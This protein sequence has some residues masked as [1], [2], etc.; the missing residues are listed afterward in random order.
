MFKFAGQARAALLGSLFAIIGFSYALATMDGANGRA[1][2]SRVGV[3]STFLHFTNPFVPSDTDR[4]L[5]D[6]VA[7]S[8]FL[9]IARAAGGVGPYRFAS[10]GTVNQLLFSEELENPVWDNT[11]GAYII[12]P[13]AAIAPDGNAGAER[14]QKGNDAATDLLQFVPNPNLRARTVTFSIFIRLNST[15]ALG[16]KI[17]ITIWD[18]VSG[19]RTR[20]VL[21]EVTTTGFTRVALT[22]VIHAD[23]TNAAVG[24]GLGMAPDRDFFAWGAQLEIGSEPTGYLKTTNVPSS[25]SPFGVIVPIADAIPSVDGKDGIQ[26]Q[27]SVGLNG[28]V[29][30][31]TTNAFNVS[32]VRFQIVVVDKATTFQ[33]GTNGIGNFRTEF[34]RLTLVHTDTF[35]F[36]IDGMP[37]AVQLQDYFMPL[38]VIN[39]ITLPL[40]FTA[41]NLKMNGVAI[42]SLEDIGLSLSVKDGVVFGKPLVAGTLTFT[43]K[44][45]NGTNVTA[46]SRDASKDDQDFTLIIDPNTIVTTTL[47]T[48][49]LTI[50][51]D[52]SKRVGTVHFTGYPH[53]NSTNFKIL[54]GQD[55][56]LRVGSYVA[57][58][59]NL[60]AQVLSGA[61]TSIK[62]T[63]TPIAKTKNNAI[64]KGKL[65]SKGLLT[66]SVTN[67]SFGD[68]FEPLTDGKDAT[69]AVYT[70]IGGVTSGSEMLRF[71]VKKRGTKFSLTY[72]S[73]TN[74]S[75]GGGF[76]LT[77]VRAK[78]LLGGSA[79][80]FKVGFVAFPP[81]TA[82]GAKGTYAG[83]N[84]G[85]VLIG[86]FYED[87]F[88]VTEKGGKVSF[89]GTPA[90]GK[91]AK[92]SMDPK[93]GKGSMQTGFLDANQ[94]GVPGASTVQ[95]GA[96]AN[97]T[98]HV[99]LSGSGPIFAGEGGIQIF[100]R[101]TDWAENPVRP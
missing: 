98:M 39:P 89:S 60:P 42:N 65:S 85:Q 15:P 84:K 17:P 67:E 21:A 56:Q 79:D 91:V 38:A 94:T 75:L 27:A 87:D 73:G 45:V 83:A 69:F 13:N 97:F 19:F 52:T 70:R 48:T 90:A 50:K 18:N 68:V 6:I 14:F 22:T 4:D 37:N 20:D 64:F 101:K 71:K 47:F 7:G 76:L 93:S 8:S 72:K 33:S 88:A 16:G 34:F 40:K 11:K 3:G 58:N 53:L 95:E 46:K 81:G 63:T 10:A 32:P 9:R 51:G 29:S 12:T 36:A 23:S 30:G 55:L 62:T 2:A 1:V 77:S 82:T 78:D 44:C 57:P 24:F 41:S 66:M 96:T 54:I 26:Q 31:V 28:L 35:R 92:L 43:C 25:T 80:A 61:G 49:G 74:T 99:G 86:S 100:S 5:G 59:P